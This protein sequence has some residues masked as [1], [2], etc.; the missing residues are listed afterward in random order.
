M[1]IFN[2][3]V[4]HYQRV[5]F[6]MRTC[7]LF[8]GVVLVLQG[9]HPRWRFRGVSREN[10]ALLVQTGDV[11][12]CKIT[13]K[14][15][16]MS[17]KMQDSIGIVKVNMIKA[18]VHTRPDVMRC[19]CWWLKTRTGNCHAIRL[20]DLSTCLSDRQLHSTLEGVW[21]LRTLPTQC[22]RGAGCDM[23]DMFRVLI[24]QTSLQVI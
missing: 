5:H 6:T 9:L 1:A 3:Y 18:L 12:E 10:A 24:L 16:N 13:R 22:G 4:S 19:R 14:I 15:W 8:L 7:L 11:N 20:G 23:R 21:Y 17:R 2:S